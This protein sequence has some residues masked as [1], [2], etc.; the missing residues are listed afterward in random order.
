MPKEKKKK[1]DVIEVDL[2]KTLVPL[3]ILLSAILSTTILSIVLIVGLYSINS[4]IKEYGVGGGGDTILGEEEVPPSGDIAPQEAPEPTKGQT[5]VDDDP[6]LGSKEKAKVAIVEFSDFECPFCKRFHEN[7]FDEI[8]DN[9]VRKDEAIFVYRDLPLSFHDP[10][11]SKQA[12]AAECVQDL[13]GNNKY[14]EYNKSIYETTSSNGQGMEEDAL[15]TLAEKVGVDRG[16]FADCYESEKFKEEV[17]KDATDAQAAGINGTPGFV[18]GVLNDDGSVDGEVV[19]GAQP[20]SVFEEAIKR[21]LDR[22][23]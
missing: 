16:K 5:S 3:S 11:A 21:Q 8:I 6:Y 20:F 18:I 22:A 4:N 23:N 13:E 10:L 12:L 19:S 7:T 15:Y 2:H 17:K 1:D 9:Y 14:F